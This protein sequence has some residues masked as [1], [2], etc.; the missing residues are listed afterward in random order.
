MVKKSV[1]HTVHAADGIS[2]KARWGWRPTLATGSS[3]M[4]AVGHRKPLVT[5]AAKNVIQL[6]Q[7]VLQQSVVQGHSAFTKQVA[8]LAALQQLMHM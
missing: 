3:H 4:Y 1:L 2:V 5:H 6:C 8:C 7:R